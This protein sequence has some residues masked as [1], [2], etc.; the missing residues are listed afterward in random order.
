MKTTVI[1]S[2]DFHWHDIGFLAKILIFHGLLGKINCQDL[3]K[4]SK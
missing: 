1:S 2:P 4:K 3:G